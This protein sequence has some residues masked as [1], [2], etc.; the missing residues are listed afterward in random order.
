MCK[1]STITIASFNK[2]KIIE[3]WLEGKGS[4]QIGKEPQLHNPHIANN[5]GNFDHRRNL[6]A[7][8]G[9]NRTCLAQTDN[10]NANKEYSKKKNNGRRQ[11]MFARKC[12]IISTLTYKSQPHGKMHKEMTE[13]N[14]YCYGLLLLPKCGH[15]HAKHN[16]SLFFSLTTADI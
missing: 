6:E 14:Y 10:G 12:P 16:I 3:S 11:C 13:I 1:S 7:E 5:V 9:G 2:V 8:K 4:I 15:F